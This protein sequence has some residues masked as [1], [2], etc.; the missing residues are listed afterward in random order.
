MVTLKG[1]VAYLTCALI[2]S[3]LVTHVS[4]S[5]P[6]L[7]IIVQTEK[8]HYHYRQLVNIYGNVTYLGQLVEEGLVAIQITFPSGL[9]GRNATRTV[10]AN[11]TPVDNWEVEI[12]SFQTTDEEG[13]PQTSFVKGGNAWFEVTLHNN[14]QYLERT[15]L[16]VLT[17]CDCDSAPFKS[18]S[19]RIRVPAG[20]GF[21]ERTMIDLNAWTNV[22][23]NW[24]S[25][26]TATAY[27]N[28]YTNWPSMGGSP[29][30]PEWSAAFTITTSGMQTT[31]STTQTAATAAPTVSHY[32]SYQVAIRL[33]PIIPLA[34]YTVTASAYYNGFRGSYTTA[35]FDRDY[36]LRGDIIYNRKLDIFDMV[37]VASAYGTKG[38]MSRWN[39]EAD[40]D[41]NAKVDV[42]DVVTAAGHY[43]ETY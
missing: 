11:A 6:Q 13:D 38:G 35:T 41:V 33:P 40:L 1:P 26:G 29:Y 34:T 30:C 4:M 15:V 10:P 21:T 32:N 37:A 2:T 24:L 25:T 8:S 3:F 12:V 43:G 16:Y 36:E 14:N 31:T 7:S 42:F 18:R 20:G 9:E 28:I 23:G 27:A 22:G 5:A 19:M 39:P 17:L